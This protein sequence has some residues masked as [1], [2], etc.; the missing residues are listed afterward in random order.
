VWERRRSLT[1]E[2][3]V[4]I[5]ENLAQELKAR[6]QEADFDAASV[7]VNINPAKPDRADC[8][9]TRLVKYEGLRPQEPGIQRLYS[10]EHGGGA[11]RQEGQ[12][13]WLFTGNGA[14]QR[15]RF[16]VDASAEMRVKPDETKS[17]TS[18][19]QKSS[20]GSVQRLPGDGPEEVLDLSGVRL[21]GSDLAT[22]AA[23]TRLKRLHLSD[24]TISDDDLRHLTRLSNLEQLYLDSTGISDAG[25]RHLTSLTNLLSL[26]SHNTK[27]TREGVAALKR[28]LPELS[29]GVV[30]PP[31]TSAAADGHLV[32]APEREFILTEFNNMD[33]REGF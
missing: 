29:I 16:H 26:N 3:V 11:F 30:F 15:L 25:L 28:V 33:G 20:A 24:S 10:A 21:T 12:G 4:R 7:S 32:F 2:A 6:L 17:A 19:T 27:V 23:K 13:L 31:D 18:T 22:I 9:I 14:L 8:V 5:E 1:A